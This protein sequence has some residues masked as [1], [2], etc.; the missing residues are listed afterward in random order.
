MNK[1][2]VYY[3][4]NLY[5]N[6]F[7]FGSRV[8]NVR[9]NRMSS[10]DLWKK[11]FTHSNNI[12]RLINE[13]GKESF[14][15]K[16]LFESDD[17]D[18]IFWVEQDYIKNN[19][20]DP[21]CLNRHYKDKDKNQKVFSFGGRKHREESKKMISRPAW[22]KGLNKDN[23]EIIKEYSKKLQ[24]ENNPC[25]GKIYS[26]DERKSMSIATTGIPKTEIT[27][28]QMRKPKS[29]SHRKNQSIS[30]LKRLKIECEF[31]G[32]KISQPNIN[33]HKKVHEK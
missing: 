33:L 12:K 7:Y 29:E 6:E 19:I 1:G 22:N 11:Y 15:V 21:L 23:N 24:G 10:E 20:K 30:A 3:I 18:L 25:Y 27:K 13:Y 5:T 14:E 17:F 4:K 26:E 9:E 8:A 32:R 2:Y 28:K 31:C 16:V